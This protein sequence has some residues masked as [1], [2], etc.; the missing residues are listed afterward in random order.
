[1]PTPSLAFSR[2]IEAADAVERSWSLSQGAVERRALA[3]FDA[4][5][6]AV[7]LLG[8]TAE[9]LGVPQ[10]L[11]AAW[12]HALPGADAIGLALRDDL[13]SVRLYTQ[14]WDAVV[15]RVRAGQDGPCPLYAGFKALPDGSARI[16]SYICLPNA[17][18][19]EFMPEIEGALT[20]FGAD[21]QALDEAF[22]PLTPQACIFTRTRAPDR[23]SWLATLR[24]AELSPASMATAL[25][26]VTDRLS[27]GPE[28]AQAV[29]SR[30]LLHVA[31]GEDGM[32]GRFLTLYTE[33]DPANLADFIRE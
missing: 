4:T 16:D 27:D 3:F 14:Y 18:R 22:R 33:T 7:G 12:Q 25:S 24:R 26:G 8:N 5:D 9:V 23:T 21:P 31:G 1:M 6:A 32:K 30:R 20:A 15:A 10:P 28:I 11:I 2:L 29:R 19:A 13:K 17:P